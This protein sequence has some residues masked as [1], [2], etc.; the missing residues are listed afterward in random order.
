[1][2]QGQLILQAKYFY[3]IPFFLILLILSLKVYENLTKTVEVAC[4]I[5]MDR[6]NYVSQIDNPEKEI[7]LL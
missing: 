5:N 2:C 7:K 1:M 4:S 3:V 6:I